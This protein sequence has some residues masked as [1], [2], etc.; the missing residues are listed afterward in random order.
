MRSVTRVLMCDDCCCGTQRKHPG[1]DHAGIRDRLS[2]AVRSAG[3]RSRCVD[4]LGVC[5]ES[6]VV[7]VKTRA[8]GTFW[9]GGVLDEAIV[10]ELEQWL[11]DNTPLPVPAA[12][13]I[14]V[15]DR[16]AIPDDLHAD[17]EPPVEFV[18]LQPRR[19]Q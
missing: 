14:R 16:Q 4:C 10:T 17:A 8:A 18:S 19:S 2:A 13:S 15:F 5:S 7:A 9:I 1:I 3:G 12:I 6:N 11:C